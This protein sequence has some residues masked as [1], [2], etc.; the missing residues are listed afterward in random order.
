MVA[1]QQKSDSDFM[2]NSSSLSFNPADGFSH[3]PASAQESAPDISQTAS[4]DDLVKV[5]NTA[6][7]STQNKEPR[8][9]SLELHSLLE[10]PAFRAILNSVRHLSRSQGISEREGAESV[11]RAFRKMDQIWSDYIFQEGLD[12]VRGPSR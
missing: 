9:V 6:L 8:D 11:I 1:L 2:Q 12:R 4:I 3:S 5:F 10:S 7:V